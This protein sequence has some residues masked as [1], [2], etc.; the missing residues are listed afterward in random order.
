[1]GGEQNASSVTARS[2][3]QLEGT[4]SFLTLSPEPGWLSMRPLTVRNKRDF[5][6][7]GRTLFN[8]AENTASS[9]KQLWAVTGKQKGVLCRLLLCPNL[10][11]ATTLG[12]SMGTVGRGTGEFRGNFLQG[13]VWSGEEVFST[14]LAFPCLQPF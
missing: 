4:M 9:Y 13:V 14:Q 5:S 11:N 12:L 1:M 8:M 10:P 3:L 6:L 2:D 7:R